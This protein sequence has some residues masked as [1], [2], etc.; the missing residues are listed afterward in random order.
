[1]INNFNEFFKYSDKVLAI[2]EPLA[3]YF[4]VEYFA[5]KRTY[6]N[7]EKLF[8]FSSNEVF[9]NYFSKELFLLGNLDGPTHFYEN[10]FDLWDSLPDPYGI[11]HNDLAPFGIGNGIS[12]CKKQDEYCEFFIIASS[13]H[14]TQIKS[15]Y[16]NN[17]SILE[18]IIFYFQNNIKPILKKL[19][20]HKILLPYVGHQ[21]YIQYQEQKRLHLENT[22]CF[23]TENLNI[24]IEQS[25]NI[26]VQLSKRELECIHYIMLGSTNR[27][28]A[29]NLEISTRTVEDYID[30]IRRKLDCKNKLEIISKIKDYSEKG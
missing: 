14:N 3:K 20:N 5:Y 17:F 18:K 12:I 30:R 25:L 2:V 13:L 21:D 4:G 6:N 11:Y 26:P 28:I 23:I 9:E 24:L 7:G 19:E 1:M 15:F 29:E 10:S 22:K 16:I 27:L 8:L